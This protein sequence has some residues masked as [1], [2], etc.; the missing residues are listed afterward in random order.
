MNDSE[1]KTDLGWFTENDWGY[2][3]KKEGNSLYGKT[4][5][6][7]LIVFVRKGKVIL[8]VQNEKDDSIG[9]GH[10]VLIPSFSTYR[11]QAEEDLFCTYCYFETDC[12]LILRKPMAK[13]KKT[14][15]TL[16][17]KHAVLRIKESL[18]L[19]LKLQ[20]FYMEG[21]GIH[22][23]S[24]SKKKELFKLLFATYS[25][26]E[27]VPFLSPLVGESL[28]FKEKIINYAQEAKTV[29][30]LAQLT[31]YST[32]GFIKKFRKNFNESP[33]HWML[34]KKVERI[35]EDLLSGEMNLQEIANKYRFFPYSNFTLFCKKHIGKVPSEIMKE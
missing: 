2:A 19:F 20:D 21:E 3:R 16:N 11:I 10:A 22:E 34:R 31:N 33:Y 25:S 7:A 28:E 30:D 14:K 23:F 4:K 24:K 8:S 6:A 15:Y 1:R 18:H 35:E 26:E 9:E 27:A 5:Q 13:L 32:S 12:L 17:G 29:N